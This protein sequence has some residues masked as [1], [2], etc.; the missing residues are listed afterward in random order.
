MLRGT[1]VTEHKVNE[2]SNNNNAQPT[3]RRR[4]RDR[5]IAQ[6]ATLRSR[7]VNQARKAGVVAARRGIQ[8]LPKITLSYFQNN[9]N[10]TNAPQTLNERFSVSRPQRG[11]QRGRGGQRGRGTVDQFASV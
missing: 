6:A 8:V 5:S 1:Q 4:V 2:Q 3:Q 7:A 10:N 9:N 11:T